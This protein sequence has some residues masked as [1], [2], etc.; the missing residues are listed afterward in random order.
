MRQPCTS[1]AG[2][3]DTSVA[4]VEAAKV[5]ARPAHPERDAHAAVKEYGQ[6]CTMDRPVACAHANIRAN[7]LNQLP[8]MLVERFDV[9]AIED[10]NVEG[11]LKNH[12]QARVIADMSPGEFRR[13][14]QYQAAQRGKTVSVVD[15]CY[16]SSK[17]C[18]ACGYKRAKMPL[19]VRAWMC[20]A[21]GI[22]QDRD[23]NAAINLRTVAES[24]VGSFPPVPA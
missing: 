15:R 2:Y 1:Y 4:P 19:S 7:A 13:P 23:I 21:C 9:I 3:R 8:P 24:S 20:P 11:M 5:E 12:K 22:H 14:L 10:L 16:P 18:S 6:N 17:T